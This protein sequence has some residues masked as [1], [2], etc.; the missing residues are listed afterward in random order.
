ML[1][2]KLQCVGL[3]VAYAVYVCVILLSSLWER[4]LETDAI[5]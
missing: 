1:L 3:I 2:K 4:D 5:V